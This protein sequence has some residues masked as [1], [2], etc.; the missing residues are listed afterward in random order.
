MVCTYLL[1]GEKVTAE[2]GVT[3][4]QLLLI[5]KIEP[6][7]VVVEVNR[8]IVLREKFATCLISEGDLVEVLH[9]VGGG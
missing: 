9:F 2:V 1:N 6:S 4:E 7:H 3:V 5:R 8:E